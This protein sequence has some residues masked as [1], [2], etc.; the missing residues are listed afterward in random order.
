MSP[1]CI[2]CRIASKEAAAA[3]LYEDEHCVVFRDTNPQA[4]IHLLVIPRKHL[5]S[6]NDCIDE[7]KWLLGHMLEVVGRMA[8]EQEIDGSGFRTVVNTN[9]EAGQT[10]FHLHIHIL[11]GRRL[12]WPPG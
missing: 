9:A 8:R 1:D 3:I 6:L 12:H 7:D 11:G 10:V 2:F 5:S 4:P